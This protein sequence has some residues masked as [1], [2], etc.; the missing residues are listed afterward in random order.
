MSCIRGRLPIPS[1]VIVWNSRLT[2]TSACELGRYSVTT[3]AMRFGFGPASSARRVPP[4]DANAIATKITSS[5][6]FIL[7]ITASF[8]IDNVTL[9]HNNWALPDEPQHTSLSLL[10]ERD[11]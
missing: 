11:P 2:I 7:N 5:S 3:A 6:G 1:S 4:F 8:S 9:Y 10:E